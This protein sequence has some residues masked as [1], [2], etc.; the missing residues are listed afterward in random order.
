MKLKI[1]EFRRDPKTCKPGLIEAS[2]IFEE[3]VEYN[4][5]QVV[6]SDLSTRNKL[7][8]IQHKFDE[9]GKYKKLATSLV[10]SCCEELGIEQ[11]RIRNSSE[12]LSSL[13]AIMTA[14]AKRVGAKSARAWVDNK[15][16]LIV[17]DK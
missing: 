2:A 7:W 3:G 12:F 4:M 8:I 17:G 1:D 10:R 11:P 16:R 6:S 5:T 9:A 14:K 15:L 13:K